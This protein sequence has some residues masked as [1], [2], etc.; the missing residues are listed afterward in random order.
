MG[1][2][3]AELAAEITGFHRRLVFYSLTRSTALGHVVLTTA[4]SPFSISGSRS[5]LRSRGTTDA[6]GPP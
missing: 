4:L 1:R 5:A 3:S 6:R 2:V